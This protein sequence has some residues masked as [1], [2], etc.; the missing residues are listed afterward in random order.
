[1][2]VLNADRDEYALY[3]VTRAKVERVLTGMWNAVGPLDR[4]EL[5]AMMDGAR[6]AVM[7]WMPPEKK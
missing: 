7:E 2:I 1:M 6:D 4:E 5:A 3:R